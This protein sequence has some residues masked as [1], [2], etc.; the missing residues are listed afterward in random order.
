MKSRFVSSCYDN[1][2]L[3]F[4]MKEDLLDVLIDD[5]NQGMKT[6]KTYGSRDG[7]YNVYETKSYYEERTPSRITPSRGHL[8]SRLRQPDLYGSSG[9]LSPSRYYSDERAD[10]ANRD[11]LRTKYSSRSVS[12]EP[13]TAVLEDKWYR[14]VERETSQRSVSP[15]P[16]SGTYTE[17]GPSGT[18]RPFSVL[19]KSPGAS[20]YS[21]RHGSRAA[22][23]ILKN[24]YGSS[25]S[26]S[27]KNVHIGPVTE[28]IE[29]K[30]ELE[31]AGQ[32]EY[33]RGRDSRQGKVRE[34]FLEMFVTLVLRGC[35]LSL[36]TDFCIS[37]V[38]RSRSSVKTASLTK[39][40]SLTNKQHRFS[41]L[42]LVYFLQNL[43]VL[44]LHLCDSLCQ[45]DM[46]T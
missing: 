34:C 24:R 41:L 18:G 23:P 19:S 9:S 35:S 31:R 46:D 2:Y 40:Q 44:H 15:R 29:F 25:R 30:R 20:P 36:L 17:F 10:S 32:Q 33:Y 8:E 6:T 28:M 3:S 21:S 5:L 38:S 13:K 22:S 1:Y 39:F 4:I 7:R 43:D 12:R 26:V 27:P 14:S 11:Y 37:F 16:R 45:E 42:L